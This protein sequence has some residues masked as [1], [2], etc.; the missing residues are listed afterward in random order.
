[1][2]QATI[3]IGPIWVLCVRVH[4][5]ERTIDHEPWTC[6]ISNTHVCIY[7]IKDETVLSSEIDDVYKLH[8]HEF[9]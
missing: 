1:V 7:V 3:R 9:K 6:I 4:E 5:T 8:L 2:P